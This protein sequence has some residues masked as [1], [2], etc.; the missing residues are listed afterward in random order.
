[1]LTRIGRKL[2]EPKSLVKEKALKEQKNRD[3][4][5]LKM[6]RKK[7]EKYHTVE[8]KPMYQT[9]NPKSVVMQ[10]KHGKQRIT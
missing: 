1:M 10:K 7:K 9:H 4:R 6:K 5:F 8:K 3:I 2:P